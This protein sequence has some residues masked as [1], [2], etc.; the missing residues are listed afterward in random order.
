MM[1]ESKVA[2]IGFLWLGCAGWAVGVARRKLLRQTLLEQ[3]AGDGVEDSVEEVDGLGGGVAAAYFEGL[4]NDDGGGG[5][6]VA[7]HLGDGSADEVAVDDSHALDAP[8][9]GVRFDEG[10]D[11]FLAGGGDSM[12]IFGEASG[13]GINVF[14]GGPE[15]LADFFGGLLA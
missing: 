7:D 2:G 1:M 14:D 12:E 9:L 11:L 13:L 15:E 3:I 4:V 10:V 6:G 5:V 8:V